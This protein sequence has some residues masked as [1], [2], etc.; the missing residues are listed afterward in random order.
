MT[1]SDRTSSTALVTGASRGFGRAIASALH[2]EGV[3]VVAVA[4]N[5][6]LLASLRRELGGTFTTEV[7]DVADPVLAG[8]LIEQYLPDTL[9]L[10]AGA[11]PLMRP[12]H[13][14]TWES[15]S[16]IWDVDVRHAFHWIRE[17]MLLPLR[18]GGSRPRS[19]TPLAAFGD[20]RRKDGLMTG[21]P[22]WIRAFVAGA[23]AARDYFA[24]VIA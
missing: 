3:E 8:T 4:R 24:A 13:Q 14:Q 16:R 17:A 19:P 11:A 22:R 2:A 1:T 23:S 10:N 6:E 9:V 18:P 15:F 7:G 20:R 21:N 12:L 5:A